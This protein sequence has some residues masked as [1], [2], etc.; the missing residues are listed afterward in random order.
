MKEKRTQI[1]PRH[2]P[3][4]KVVTDLILETFQLNGRLLA[5]GDRL[6]RDLRV[7]SARWQVMGAIADTPL[8]VAQIAR[9]MGLT[10]QSVQR[11]ADILA[12][13]DLVA[14]TL[15]PNHQKAKLVTLT[16][17]GKEV[18]QEVSR[19]QILWANELAKGLAATELQAAVH[20]IETVRKRLEKA[21]S[22]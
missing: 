19:R 21:R 6:T 3:A 2:T 5:A 16:P 4:G 20:L 1:M 15:N 22:Q 13:E 18:L 11:I 17:H 14:F 9:R 12:E 10:R 8:P 7:S